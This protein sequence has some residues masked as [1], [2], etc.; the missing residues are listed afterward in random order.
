[1]CERSRHPTV[2]ELTV[3]HESSGFPRDDELTPCGYPAEPGSPSAA[4]R[5]GQPAPGDSPTRQPLG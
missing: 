3:T 4:G 5:L 1:M 2:G